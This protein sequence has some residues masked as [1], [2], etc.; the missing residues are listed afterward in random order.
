MMNE[1]G[2][3]QQG[4]IIGEVHYNDPTAAANV[5]RAIDETGRTVFY[6]LQWPGQPH[7][8]GGQLQDAAALHEPAPS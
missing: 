7:L 2:L 5:R 8:L 3:G 6:L 4:W 1:M